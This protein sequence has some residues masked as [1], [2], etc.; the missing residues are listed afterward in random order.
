MRSLSSILL[1]V[2]AI[3]KTFA[4]DPIFPVTNYTT[5]EYGRDLHPSNMAIVQ[6]HKGI[7]YAANG[8]RL[9]EFDGHTWN[10][11]PIN[12]QAWILSIAIDKSGIIYTG[13]QKEFGYFAP[14]K[15]GLLKYTSISDSLSSEENDFTNVWKVHC[16]SEGVVFQSEENLFLYKNGKIK[17]IKPLTSFH[18]SFTVNDELYIRERGIGLMKWEDEKTVKIKG[19]EI[20]DT[21][22][23]FMMLPF[24]SNKN[25]ILIGTQEK[26]FWLFEPKNESNPFHRFEV[27][28]QDLLKG[29]KI[30]GGSLTGD[31]SFAVSTMLNGV[32]IIDTTGT[33]KTNINKKNGLIDDEIKD[34]ITDKS[35]NLW[36]ALN[37]GISTVEISSPLSIYNETSGITG[38]INTFIRH[39]KNL[40][41]GTT[42][43]LFIFSPEN[44]P[45]NTFKPLLNLEVPVRSLVE[46]EGSLI[47][48]SDNGIY[49]ISDHKT[50]KISNQE[51]YIL[52][53][54]PELKL[55]FSGGPKG[56][57]VFR[58]KESFRSVELPEKISEDIVGITEDHNK[59][60]LHVIWIGTRYDGVIRLKFDNDTLST[61]RYN[62]VDGLPGGPVFTYQYNTGTVFG[63]INGLYGFVDEESVKKSLPDSLKNNKDFLRGYFSSISISGDSINDTGTSVSAIS[64]SYDKVWVC[65]DNKISYFDKSNNMA[66]IK[67]PFLG[68]DVGKINFIYPENNGR[69]WFGTTDGLIMY[70]ELHKK[71]FTSLYNTLIRKVSL[72]DKDSTIFNGIY[73]ESGISGEINVLINQPEKQKSILPYSENTIRIEFVSPFFEHSDKISYSYCLE[74]GNSRWS[75][76]TKTNYLEYNNLSEGNYIFR[77]KSLN[78]YG[79]ES[80]EANYSF[81]ILPPWYRSTIAYLLYILSS[82][83]IIWLIARLYSYK[84]KRENI[85]LEGIVTERTAEI[86]QQKNEIENKNVMLEFQKKE[87]EDS[88]R[89]ARRI[90]S[91]VIPHEKDCSELLPASFVFFR[92]LNIVSGDFYWIGKANDK[93]IFTAADCTGHGVPG[94]FMSMLGV[95]F[96]NEIVN[97]D[98]ISRP[99]LILNC[100]RDKVIH[101]LQ[102]QGISGEARDGMDIAL[103]CIDIKAG[104][105]Q[106]SGAYNSLIMIRDGVIFETDGDKMPVGFYEKMNPFSLHETATYK[107]DLFYMASDGFEDQFGGPDGKKFKSKRFKQMLLEISRYP[108][109]SQKELVEK[110]FEEWK[111]E[112]NQIDDIVVTGF[113]IE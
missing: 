78:V 26:G 100:L 48:A 108:I 50:N 94:A 51:S 42:T 25:K 35:N 12:K 29:M 46:A 4:Q 31:G 55:L 37:N 84:L 91:A 38:S 86:V 63:T 110:H 32:I 53:Y 21:T 105:L 41:V 74:G 109:K 11:Y 102:Q 80:S 88:I 47:A 3:S 98:N 49:I 40:Y 99:D 33:I 113:Q 81:T 73:F 106:Y 30:T 22:G 14:D 107:G 93:I 27:Q 19:G 15:S 56:L 60:D 90:Q 43:G 59:K 64:E 103:V 36:L 71:D 92:P 18:T 7:I 34:I 20:F 1:F 28:N 62:S 69:C 85:R 52:Y 5:K 76:W 79:V 96:L 23:I 111:G 9:L 70:D 75:P 39:K 104:M 2:F 89:Y 17:I 72:P 66:L 57:F 16:L 82:A 112:Y 44:E 6:D 87:I 83:V 24:G 8:F 101:A 77:V 54:S 95:A 97:K 67:R 45:K 61:E 13:S 65:S 58:G 68:I 10:S